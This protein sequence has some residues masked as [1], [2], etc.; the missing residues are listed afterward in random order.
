M[1]VSKEQK[2]IDSIEARDIGPFHPPAN[3]Q[4]EEELRAPIPR[5]IPSALRHGLYERYN[6]KS[7]LIP[8]V[9]GINVMIFSALPWMQEQAQTFPTLGWIKWIAI[10]LVAV[11]IFRYLRNSQSKVAYPFVQSGTPIVARILS[12]WVQPISLNKGQ[13]NQFQYRAT[14]EYLDPKSGELQ[15]R[16]VPSLVISSSDHSRVQCTYRVGQYATALH[17]PGSTEK[18]IMLYGLLGLR[19]DLGIIDPNPPIYFRY[20]FLTTLNVGLFLLAISISLI[21]RFGYM[22]VD[23]VFFGLFLPSGIIG[24][25]LSITLLIWL[26]K[27]LKKQHVDTDRKNEE[28]LT[29]GSAIELTV[30]SIDPKLNGILNR[31]LPA[32][33]IILGTMT[34]SA[35]V[36]YGILAY[37]NATMDTSPATQRYV[38]IVDFLENRDGAAIRSHGIIYQFPGERTKRFFLT[39]KA[40]MEEFREGADVAIAKVKRGWLG[41]AWVSDLLPMPMWNERTSGPSTEMEEV[42][43]E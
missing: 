7:A 21:G 43:A 2:L 28:A 13:P 27:D 4:F 6:V 1:S 16:H 42:E 40:R 17:V 35:A 24:L 3:Y 5:P 26:A 39:S 8:F 14:I 19:N 25:L 41:A 29:N 34:V 12:L 15:T 33:G 18:N 11:G 20:A 10:G 9:T 23:N 38:G 32:A 31:L 37:V 36:L 22:P 30:S